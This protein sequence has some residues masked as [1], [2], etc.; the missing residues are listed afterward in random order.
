MMRRKLV[1]F[2]NFFNLKA[3]IALFILVIFYVIGLFYMSLR[4]FRTDDPIPKIRTVSVKMRKAFRDLTT[5][6]RTGLFIK[7]FPTFDVPNNHFVVDAVLWFECNKNELMLKTLDEFSFDNSEILY[8]SPPSI[9]FRHDKML[10]IY[11]II[12]EVATDLDF[13]RFPLED[14]RVSL[15][16]TN[17]AVTPNEMYFDDDIN[18]I[19][20][21]ISDRLFT[22]NWLVHS[23]KKQPGY[24]TVHIDAHH[25]QKV[26]RTPKVVFTINFQKAGINKILIIFVPL[27]LTILLALLTFLLSFNSTA[28]KTTLSVTAVTALLGYRFVI[29]QL[30]PRVGYFTITDQLFIFFIGLSFLIMLFQMLLLRQYMLLSDREKISKADQ[31]ENDTFYYSPRITERINTLAYF[32][33]LLIFII[34]VTYLMR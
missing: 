17:T 11:D 28:A 4:T 29:Q 24:T 3:K 5:K 15:V 30:S 22:T 14:H 12:L 25:P 10:V 8:K 26:I 20:L 16:L 32:C 31:P 21:R 1:S 33:A 9:S 13:R 18:G 23:L 6:V 2:F 34:F 19:S 7:N 27:F